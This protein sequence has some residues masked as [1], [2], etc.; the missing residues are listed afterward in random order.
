MG[1]AWDAVTQKDGHRKQG[2]GWEPG[3]GPEEDDNTN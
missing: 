2:D 1:S 3:R